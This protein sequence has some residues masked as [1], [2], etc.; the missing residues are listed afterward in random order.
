VGVTPKASTLKAAITSTRNFI[1]SVTFR[2]STF[3]DVIASTA[4]MDSG[5]AAQHAAGLPGTL[6]ERAGS[7]ITSSHTSLDL[8]SH[9]AGSTWP[10]GRHDEVG[11]QS[12]P[13]DAAPLRCEPLQFL[14]VPTTASWPTPLETT[15]VIWIRHQ[16]LPGRPHTE[17]SQAHHYAS[18]NSRRSVRQ[19]LLRQV[20][21]VTRRTGHSGAVA[22]SPLLRVS[23]TGSIDG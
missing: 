4:L 22:T 3:Q 11:R 17:G 18:A 8:Q 7:G 6:A 20:L 21:A 9:L 23:V 15:S 13:A 2:T 5:A 14:A 19:R 12:P 16:R 10:R 1:A